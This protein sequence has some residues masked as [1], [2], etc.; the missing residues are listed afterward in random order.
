MRKLKGVRAPMVLAISA[1]AVIGLIGTAYAALQGNENA[2]KG[3]VIIGADND[4][5]TDPTIQPPGVA[6]NQSLNKSDQ[7]VGGKGSDMLIGRLGP[8][9]I[10]A[11]AGNDVIIGGTERGQP[12]PPVPNNDIAF[13]GTGSDTFIWAPGDGS[14]AFI[15]GNPEKGA[16]KELCKQKDKKKRKKCKKG[17]KDEDTLVLGNLQLSADRSL[18]ELFR[19]N[20][21]DVPKQLP[22][23]FSS[24]RGVPT[25]LGGTPPLDPVLDG[26]CQIVE[27]PAGLEY[28][29]LVRFF[30]GPAGAQ[31]VTIRVKGVEQVVCPTQGTDAATLT[32]LGKTGSGPL[33]VRSTDFSA[34]KKSILREFV[35]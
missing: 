24:D 8:D 22:R 3:K 21:R 33:K 27:S 25:P 14:D 20:K 17:L 7:I 13:G 11:N 4:V 34:P 28:D 15:G 10:T 12:A 2:K 29:F 30:A 16:A 26:F 19:E 6:A 5:D 35:N 18:P 32:T 23:V 9:V 31:A 1:L